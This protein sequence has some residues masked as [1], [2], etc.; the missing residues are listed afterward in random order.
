MG[1]RR[2]RPD[3]WEALRAIRVRALEESPDAFGSTALEALQRDD[4]Q[5]RA[6]AEAGASSATTALFVAGDNGKIVGL[7]GT[8]VHEDDPRTAQIVAMWVEPECRGRRLGEQLLDAAT[9][10]SEGRGARQ[11]VLDVTEA[12]EAAR[13]LYGRAGFR[14]TGAKAPLRSNPR[15]STVEMRKQLGAR[16]RGPIARGSAPSRRR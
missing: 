16:S 8:F 5:W 2:V 4:G 1:V 12:N 13:R 10:W 11:L 3:E 14:E 15:L 9:S 7:C 6:W